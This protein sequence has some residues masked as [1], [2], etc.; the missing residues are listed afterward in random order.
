[1]FLLLLFSEFCP[2]FCRHQHHLLSPVMLTRAHKAEAEAVIIG[3]WCTPRSFGASECPVPTLCLSFVPFPLLPT[4][5][6]CSLFIS[7]LPFLPPPPSYL[8]CYSA[9]SEA[10]M[11]DQQLA[12]SNQQCCRER[13]QRPQIRQRGERR[14]DEKERGRERKTETANG[15][16]TVTTGYREMTNDTDGQMTGIEEDDESDVCE[17]G[18]EKQYHHHQHHHHHHR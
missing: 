12:N 7:V 9:A 3:T 13:S 8:T 2:V 6:G 18:G 14:K 10:E 17:D 1:M 16:P 4:L 11:S 5:A 15:R